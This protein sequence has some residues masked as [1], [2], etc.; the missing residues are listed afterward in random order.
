MTKH[1]S[2]LEDD[3]G[4]ERWIEEPPDIFKSWRDMPSAT[5]TNQRAAWC[6]RYGTEYRQL[7]VWLFNGR[8]CRDEDLLSTLL[9][10]PFIYVSQKQRDW[11]ERI[12][13]RIH[14]FLCVKF[15][16]SGTRRRD[17]E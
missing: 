14:H 5:N 13:E 9:E 4:P 6:L 11:L 3:G 17:D 2:L 15:G 16:G 12:E 1:R 7:K 8:I 10:L